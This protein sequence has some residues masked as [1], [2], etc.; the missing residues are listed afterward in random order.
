MNAEFARIEA[1]KADELARIEAL[2]AFVFKDQAFQI[3]T[4]LINVCQVENTQNF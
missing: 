1:R 3:M 4:N 2:K